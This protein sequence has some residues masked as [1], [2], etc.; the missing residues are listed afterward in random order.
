MLSAQALVLPSRTSNSSKEPSVSEQSTQ[1]LDVA[2]RSKARVLLQAEQTPHCHET[3]WLFF[4]DDDHTH[5][6]AHCC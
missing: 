2:E 3:I 4:S 1:R 5:V 6:L